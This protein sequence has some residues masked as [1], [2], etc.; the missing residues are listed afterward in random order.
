MTLPPMAKRA[1]VH[2]VHRVGGDGECPRQHGAIAAPRPAPF[3][4]E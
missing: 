3:D 4:I 2:G 1:G